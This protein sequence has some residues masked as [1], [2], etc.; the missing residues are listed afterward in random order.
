MTVIRCYRACLHAL[1]F[2]SWMAQEKAPSPWTHQLV[3]DVTANQVA[4]KDWAAGG[5]DASA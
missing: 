5:D 2:L 3:G 1:L 4:L